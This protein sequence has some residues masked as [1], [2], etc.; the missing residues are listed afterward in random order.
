MLSKISLGINILLIAAVVYL[1]FQIN[2]KTEVSPTNVL[3]VNSAF[4]STEGVK[5]PIMAYING[6]SINA[7]YK[8]IVD[9]SKALEQKYRDADAKVKREYQQREA[10]AQELAAYAQK[11][12]IPDDEMRTIES[13]MQQ[14]EM[15]IQQIQQQESDRVMKKEAELQ[16]EL[17]ERV[18]KFLDGYAREKGID[19]VV[20]Y[21][22]AVQFILFGNNAYDVTS[23][24]IARLNA[25]YEQ[26]QEEKK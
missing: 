1:F 6:D 15:E 23:E 11:G 26:E 21:Q 25:E 9:R 8:F 12:N 4:N 20:N 24:V 22:P 10:E 18:Q 5:A 3:P 16:K 19:F 14:L 7:K 17:Q 2:K 13:R